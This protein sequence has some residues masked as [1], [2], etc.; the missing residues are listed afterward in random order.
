MSVAN[1]I[2]S[3]PLQPAG[4]DHMRNA[5]GVQFDS[6]RG[7]NSSIV[8]SIGSYAQTQ[9][10]VIRNTSWAQTNL[11]V[12]I[13]SA[14]APTEDEVFAAEAAIGRLK[15]RQGENVDDWANLLGSKL[16]GYVD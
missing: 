12:T 10:L 9:K 15:N 4:F 16:G 13:S 8:S 7:I 11:E 6:G 3:Q 5:V 14:A 2:V 1:K